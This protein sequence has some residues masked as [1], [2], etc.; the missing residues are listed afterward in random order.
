[1]SQ[2]RGALFGLTRREAK[3][4]APV[5]PQ[6]KINPPIAKYALAIEN[7]YRVPAFAHVLPFWISSAGGSTLSIV[8]ILSNRGR[9][10][11]CRFS[12]PAL[13][14]QLKSNGRQNAVS[15]ECFPDKCLISL[16]RGQLNLNC[17][18]ISS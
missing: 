14:L 9:I 12:G 16:G 13:G 5:K 18:R 15:E 1:V 17:Y 7:H 2:K 11:K 3:N 10:R 6:Q 4:I 8:S